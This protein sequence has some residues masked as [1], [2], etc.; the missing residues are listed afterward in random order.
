ML[1]TDSNINA[2]QDGER[3]AVL[4]KALQAIDSLQSR[5]DAFERD[6]TEPIAIVGLSCRFPGSKD[7]DAFWRLLSGGIDAVKEVPNDRWDKD[8]YYDP[9]PSVPG[10]M[11]APYG[12][13]LDQVDLFDPAFFGIS[14]REAESMDP[15]QRLLLEVAWEALENAGISTTQLRGSSTGVFVGITASEYARLA[16]ESDSGNLDVYAMTG[17]ALSVAAGRL[18]YVFGLNGPTMAV[19]TACSSSLVAVHLACQSLRARECELALAGG[20]NLL[21]A[22][23]AFVGLSKWGMMAPDGRCKTFD[24]RADGF[25][26]VE[27]CGI[28]ALKRL[29]DARIAGDRVLA[30][31]CGTAVNHD[32]ASS[33]LTV[34]NGTAQQTLLRAALNSARLQPSDVDY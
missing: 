16:T 26:R 5:L 9:D 33:G 30:L 7:P 14:G 10:K 18:S 22:P 20:V 32:G 6:R 2:R 23:Q 12:G 11:H 29:S 34:P 27:G 1:K 25:V 31:I 8:A 19:D 24:A 17:G 13:F 21:L 3:K 28:I 4:L 15:Q